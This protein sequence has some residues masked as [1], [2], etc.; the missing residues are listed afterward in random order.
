M[1]QGWGLS[2]Q[3]WGLEGAPG[4]HWLHASVQPCAPFPIL[5]APA[6]GLLSFPSF[7]PVVSVRHLQPLLPPLPPVV[8]PNEPCSQGLEVFSVSRNSQEG[9]GSELGVWAV[10]SVLG[11]VG[12][13]RVRGVDQA[14]SLLQE[15]KVLEDLGWGLCFSETSESDSPRTCPCCL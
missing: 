2:S 14:P 6:P 5:P 1:R 10:G 4:P 7:G 12:P 13:T 8:S 9:V 11:P 3:L 15:R